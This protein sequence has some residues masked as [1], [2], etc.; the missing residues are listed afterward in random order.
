MGPIAKFDVQKK[1]MCKAA[2]AGSSSWED[3]ETKV[4]KAFQAWDRDGN[5]YISTGELTVVLATLNCL[6]SV[7]EVEEMMAQADL[8]NDGNIDYEE[9]VHWFLRAPHLEEYFITSVDL[10]FDN[11]KSLY[12][13]M[14]DLGQGVDDIEG[15]KEVVLELDRIGTQA[16]IDAKL[17]PL[18]K[19]IFAYH[20]KDNSGILTYDES[21]IFFS[22][23]MALSGPYMQCLAELNASQ[24]TEFGSCTP[25]PVKLH[26]EFKAKYSLLKA[27][28][29]E[30]IDERYKA[31]FEVLS[32]D[33]QIC[34]ADLVEGLLPGHQKQR[35]FLGALGLD[36][37]LGSTGT[38][39]KEGLS[40]D[41]RFDNM[42]AELKEMEANMDAMEARMEAEMGEC[43]QQ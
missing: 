24:N 27:K 36:V 4:V 29:L 11:A 9:M 19:K 26:Q 5:G 20:D 38:T 25:A 7:S 43:P 14:K 34:E 35:E 39:S 31:A 15:T 32:Q 42:S 23:F 1:N 30:N 21:I 37:S 40:D 8:N 10:F 16:Q 17:T 12:N 18:I 2:I 3:K 41:Q 28:Q 33:G 6:T 13:E 22:N